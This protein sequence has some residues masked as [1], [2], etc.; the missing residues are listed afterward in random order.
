MPS[1]SV[2]DT[3]ASCPL[4]ISLGRSRSLGPRNVLSMVGGATVTEELIPGFRFS[5]ASYIISLFR[6]EIV[7]DL[8]LPKHGYESITQRP[9]FMC[10]LRRR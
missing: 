3:T 5:T 2:A 6:H 8:Q 4:P 9:D 10:D 7:N 1:S